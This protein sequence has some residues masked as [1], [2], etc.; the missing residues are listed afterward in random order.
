MVL[1]G[2]ERQREEVGAAAGDRT[3]QEATMTLNWI[4]FAILIV[5][6]LWHGMMP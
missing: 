5:T 3:T 6:L 2:A 1:G 4:Q